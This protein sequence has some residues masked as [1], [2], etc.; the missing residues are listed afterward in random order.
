MSTV[1]IQVETDI[2]MTEDQQNEFC[3]IATE[4]LIAQ[5]IRP[6]LKM[7]ETVIHLDEP[8]PGTELVPMDN[9]FYEWCNALNMDVDYFN[10]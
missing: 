3:A 2:P 1:R 7:F 8:E 9:D 10:N 6:A 5:G 4:W